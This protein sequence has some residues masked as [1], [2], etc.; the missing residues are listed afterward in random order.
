M[1]KRGVEI[2]SEI[3]DIS[4]NPATTIKELS[5]QCFDKRISKRWVSVDDLLSDMNSWLQ[6][7]DYKE[8]KQ[9]VEDFI[10]ELKE[11]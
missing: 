9:C 10:S 5:E 1:I 8:L 2:W 3:R 7:E 6:A 11:G 4:K